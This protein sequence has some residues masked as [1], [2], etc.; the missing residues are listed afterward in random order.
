MPN[1]HSILLLLALLGAAAPVAAQSEQALRAALEG[2]RVVLKLEMPATDDGVDLL[3]GSDRPLDYPRYAERLKRWG[4]AIRAGE[5][6]VLTKVRV[7]KDLIEV[8]LGGGGYGTFGDDTENGGASV[9][10]PKSNREKDLEAKVKAATDAA[11][12]RRLQREL[13]DL[14][15]ARQRE[16]RQQQVAAEQ[17][18][19]IR[20]ER[21]REKR[22]AGGSRFNLR[23]RTGV[24]IAEVTPETVGRLLAEYLSFDGPQAARSAHPAGTL[25]KGLTVEEV[26]ALLGRPEAI[27]PRSEGKYR[28]SVASYV[29]GV[30]RIDAEFVEGVLVAWTIRSR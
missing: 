21:V 1:R 2:R 17:A 15:S 14:R 5:S 6:I 28:V 24:P 11:E 7:K 22:L 25:R 13:D 3:V 20:D 9:S 26:D 27:A 12:R 19:A 4:T 10:I 16:E 23:W 8:Q 30:E 18:N 29:S